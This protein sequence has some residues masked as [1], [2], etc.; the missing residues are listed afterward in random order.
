[1][2]L[3]MNR[4]RITPG[5]ESAFEQAWRERDSHLDGVPGFR[6]FHLLRGPTS[7]EATLFASHTLWETRAAFEAWCDSD[8]FKQAHAKARLPQGTLLGH[9]EFEGFDFVL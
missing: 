9:P 8:A 7:E 5:Q 1:M 3:A 6:E 2:Y 4:F